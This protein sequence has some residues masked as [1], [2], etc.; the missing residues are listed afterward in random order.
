MVLTI[1][2]ISSPFFFLKY[3]FLAFY[4][5]NEKKNGEWNL[6]FMIVVVYYLKFWN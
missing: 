4:W 3:L 6:S 5:E 2:M 1:V